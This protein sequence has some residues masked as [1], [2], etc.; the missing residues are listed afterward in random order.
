MGKRDKLHLLL[1][2]KIKLISKEADFF[3]AS[4]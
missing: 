2:K 1:K 3:N 4:A